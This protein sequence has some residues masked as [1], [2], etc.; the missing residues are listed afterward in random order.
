[1]KQI[2]A[3]GAV[4]MVSE[5]DLDDRGSILGGGDMLHNTLYT[6]RTGQPKLGIQVYFWVR[7]YLKDKDKESTELRV[8]NLENE[9]SWLKA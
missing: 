4:Y 1:M 3:D 9:I 6:I 7:R 8:L 5:K 2:S